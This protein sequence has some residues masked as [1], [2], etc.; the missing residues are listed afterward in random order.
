MLPLTIAVAASLSAFLAMAVWQGGLFTRTLT[1]GVCTQCGA[2]MEPVTDGPTS[3]PPRSY[4]VVTCA[5][6]DDTVVTVHG[7]RSPHAYCPACRQLSLEVDARIGGRVVHLDEACV[8][9]GHTAS[10]QVTDTR[11]EAVRGRVIPFRRR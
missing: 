8:L 1:S 3:D 6:C 11:F 4:E 10:L 7:C 2:A 5:E 9:C